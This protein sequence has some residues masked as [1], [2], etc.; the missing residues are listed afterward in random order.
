VVVVPL[1]QSRTEEL[2]LMTEAGFVYEVF[3]APLTAGVDPAVARVHPVDP[4]AA[5]DIDDDSGWGVGARLEEFVGT[6]REERLVLLRATDVQGDVAVLVR[7]RRAIAARLDVDSEVEIADGFSTWLRI[8]LRAGRWDLRLKGAT[9]SLDAAM[10]VHDAGTGALIEANDDESDEI[11][12]PRVHLIL[13]KPTVVLI[14]L[15]SVDGAGSARLAIRP[16][17]NSSLEVAPRTKQRA[18][19]LST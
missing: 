7:A 8:E 14:R 1:G 13:D 15:I 3:A 9:E 4:A 18:S 19:E 10:L 12:S 11:L 2:A 17:G 5:A 16:D 6:G